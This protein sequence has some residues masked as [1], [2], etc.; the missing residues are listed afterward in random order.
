[1]DCQ[2][3]CPVSSTLSPEKKGDATLPH[4]TLARLY[5]RPDPVA[6]LSLLGCSS[7]C[8][9]LLG[10]PQPAAAGCQQTSAGAALWLPDWRGEDQS[11]HGHGHTCP[12]PPPRSHTEA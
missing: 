8:L 6:D 4:G 3:C 12:S 9:F 2:L 1:M 7:L 10:E 5:L 11:G